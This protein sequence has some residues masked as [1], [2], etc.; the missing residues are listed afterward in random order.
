MKKIGLVAGGALVGIIVIAVV[1]AGRM[2]E[3]S[4]AFA[5]GQVVLDD[6]VKE[7]AQGIGTLF[8]IA[9]GPDR[10]MPLG[11]LRKSMSG[12]IGS[13]VYDFVLTK[14]N[15][16]LMGGAM[17][18]GGDLPPEFKLKAR[19]DRDGTAGP[20]QPGD[21][22]GEVA[23]VQKGQSGIEIRLNRVIP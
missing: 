7:A 13:V 1:M 16:Q 11:A 8:I 19:L 20:D 15:L 21:V 4:H 17:G 12:E 9:S 23:V 14:D 2:G 18:G 5:K 10:P 6:S 3:T 22:V